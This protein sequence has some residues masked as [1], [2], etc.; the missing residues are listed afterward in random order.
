MM[1][2][3]CYLIAREIA[4]AGEVY[5]DDHRNSYEW[6]NGVAVER[7]TPIYAVYRSAN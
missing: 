5:G 7:S 3:P 6:G 1:G 2:I 4:V